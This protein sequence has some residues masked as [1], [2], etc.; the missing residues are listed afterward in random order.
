MLYD[1]KNNIFAVKTPDGIPKT[2]FKPKNGRSY[3]DKQDGK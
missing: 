1:S 3:F 2:L